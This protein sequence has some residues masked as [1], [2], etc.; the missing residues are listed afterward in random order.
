MEIKGSLIREM[1]AADCL[2]VCLNM[3]EDDYRET[4]DLTFA[5]TKEAMARVILNQNGESYTICNRK[6]NPVLIGG[7]YYDNPNVGIIWLFATD[8]ISKR[9][10]WV[11]TTFITQ[12]IE[13]MFKDG[14][15]HRIQALSIGWREVAHKW[16]QKIGLVKEGH[17][18]GFA[19]NGYDVLIFGK[20][21]EQ[22]N[23]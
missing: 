23:G 2:Y 15:A 13:V 9:D 6:G 22:K 7:T 4:S 19:E 8:E 16:L 3:R 18:K 20:I 5:K 21:K 11:T 14:S 10:W 12:L 1:T 17:L